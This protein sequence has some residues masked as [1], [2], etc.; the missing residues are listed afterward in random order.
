MV[1]GCHIHMK[2]LVA[3]STTV[4]KK[5]RNM[6][7][8]FKLTEELELFFSHDFGEFIAKLT[9]AQQTPVVL[10]VLLS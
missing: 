4:F 6:T 1:P 10:G 5:L 8:G 2:H 7:C 3:C 9:M